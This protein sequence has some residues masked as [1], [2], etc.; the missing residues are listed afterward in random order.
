MMQFILFNRMYLHICAPG[1]GIIFQNE[2]SFPASTDS[3][4][5][6]LVLITGSEISKK[7]VHVQLKQSIIMTGIVLIL[8][9]GANSSSLIIMT[10]YPPW[11]VL[12]IREG[13]AKVQDAILNRIQHVSK[14]VIDEL[15]SYNLVRTSL[16]PVD[17]QKYVQEVLKEKAMID[18]N[19]FKTQKT[20][21]M[22]DI[23]RIHFYCQVFLF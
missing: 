6:H 11:G 5:V 17:V 10:T 20:E 8:L 14:Q 3:L 16:E 15:E 21:H 12:S 9:F 4:T 1:C 18:S 19:L 22:A 2:K 23:N 13:Q 7:I